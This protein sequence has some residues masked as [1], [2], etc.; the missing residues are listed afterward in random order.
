M[1]L[2]V[3]ISF[4]KTS[5]LMEIRVPSEYTF[6]YHYYVEPLTPTWSEVPDHTLIPISH[7]IKLVQLFYRF[8][9]PWK[10]EVF[11]SMN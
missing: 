7:L 9:A 4:Q 1:N 5:F 8:I 6:Y 10:V 2:I 11:F 3:I